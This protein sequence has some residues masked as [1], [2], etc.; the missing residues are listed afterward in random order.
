MAD[1]DVTLIVN[2]VDVGGIIVGSHVASYWEEGNNLRVS[3]ISGIE[4]EV[5]DMDRLT[6]RKKINGSLWGML[7]N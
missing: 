7:W 4:L 6:F 2:S 5:K 1:I 3:L